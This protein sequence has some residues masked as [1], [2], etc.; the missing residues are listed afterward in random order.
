MC[1]HRHKSQGLTTRTP[2]L[3]VHLMVHLGASVVVF[4]TSDIR[5]VLL[6]AS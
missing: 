3:M 5:K 4:V 2:H 1:V 6:F